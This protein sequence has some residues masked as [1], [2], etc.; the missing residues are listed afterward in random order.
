MDSVDRLAENLVHRFIDGFIFLVFVGAGGIPS[1]LQRYPDL[2]DEYWW[3]SLAWGTGAL[4][5]GIWAYVYCKRV[6]ATGRFDPNSRAT[7]THNTPRGL[8]AAL[9]FMIALGVVLGRFV[10]G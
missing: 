7:L 3:L 5:F 1:F 6:H 2:Q 8:L 4:V 10:K 9:A